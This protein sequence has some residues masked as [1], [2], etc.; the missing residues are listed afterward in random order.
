MNKKIISITFFLIFV[1]SM[2]C[3]GFKGYNASA[4]VASNISISFSPN[5]SNANLSITFIATITGSTPSGVVTWSSNSSTGLF[6]VTS[7]PMI[8][9]VLVVS[10]IDTKPSVVNITA[11]YSGDTNNLPSSKTVTLTLFPVGDFNHDGVVNFKDI[12]Y[13]VN[14]YIVANNNGLNNGKVDPLC[15]LNNDGRI[16]FTDLKLFVAAYTA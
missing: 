16:N 6:N 15:D 10:Y 2:L 14:A 4:A 12:V 13:L 7:S 3:V 11:S 9:G 8:A 5:P 1:A